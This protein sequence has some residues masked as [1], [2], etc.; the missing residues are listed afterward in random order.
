[1]KIECLYVKCL[2]LRK[3]DAAPRMHAAVMKQ[4]QSYQVCSYFIL[5]F[6]L[7]SKALPNAKGKARCAHLNWLFAAILQMSRKR[8]L[9]LSAPWKADKPY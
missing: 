2:Y 7:L 6:W 3:A 8:L 9:N 1:M 5:Q 4:A